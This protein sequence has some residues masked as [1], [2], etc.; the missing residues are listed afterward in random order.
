MTDLLDAFALVALGLEEPAA[1]EVEGVLRRG[2]AALVAVNLAE[3]L[4]VMARIHDRPL[5]E[6]KTSFVPLL[7]DAARVIDADERQAWRAVELRRHYYR[8]GQSP[9]SLAD[10]FLLAAAGARDSIATT[11][12]PLAQAARAEGIKVIT[13]P[14]PDGRRP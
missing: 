5:D 7:E 10:C 14:G 8:R 6:L 9:L 1:R 4:D 2:D 12:R 11:D 3:A 13:L